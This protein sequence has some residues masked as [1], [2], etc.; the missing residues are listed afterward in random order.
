MVRLAPISARKLISILLRL[1]FVETHRSGS[2]RFFFNQASKRTATVPDHGA[3]DIGRGL[4]R[5]ILRDI[6]INL[7][8]FERLK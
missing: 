6:D 4:L 8:E 3:E 7:D 5:K 1:G 2:H